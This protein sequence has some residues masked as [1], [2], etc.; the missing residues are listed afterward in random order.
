MFLREQAAGILGKV[1]HARDIL[2]ASHRE[3]PETARFAATHGEVLRRTAA[4]LARSCAPQ[5][6]TTFE[7][8]SMRSADVLKSLVAFEIDFGICLSPQPR[9][10]SRLQNTNIFLTNYKKKS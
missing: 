1:K 6:Q 4:C 5:K 2:S 9:A 7:L 8:M 10:D 3:F